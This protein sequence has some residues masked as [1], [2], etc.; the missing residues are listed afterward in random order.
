MKN[1]APTALIILDGF[2][3]SKESEF[4][5]IAQAHTPCFDKLVSLYPTTLL[6]ASGMAVG[7]PEG[8]VGNSEV[9][10]LTIGSGA[11]ILQPF[12]ILHEAIKDG[13]F[14]TNKT[15]VENFQK[16]KKENKRL[17]IM[18]ILSNAKIHGDIGHLIAFLKAAKQ[19]EIPE[20][21][22]HCFLDGIDLPIQSAKGFLTELDEA[23]EEIG[24]GKI[25]SL[26][27]RFYAMDRTRNWH[28]TEQSFYTL[29]EKQPD[30]EKDWQTALKKSY[31]ENV[32]DAFLMPVQIENT[33]Q[34]EHG[35][36]IVFFNFRR[37]RPRQLTRA[38]IRPPTELRLKPFPLSF[39]MTPFSF[40]PNYDTT[41]LYQRP[42]VTQTLSR[43][44]HE[45]GFSLFTVAETEKFPHVTYFFNGG[46]EERLPNEKVVVVPSVASRDYKVHPE[47]SAATI[48]E[49]I[50]TSLKHKPRDLYIVN[51]ANADMVGHTG[52]FEATIKGV[53]CLD[54]Q[55]AVLY[56]EFVIKRNGTMYI[57]GDHGNAEEM[58]D[59]ETG[60]VKTS[61]TTNPV[62]FI[63]IQQQLKDVLDELPLEELSDI[64]P[65]VVHN[66][67]EE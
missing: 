50:V 57:T 43:M 27:G 64:A 34:I 40:G 8:S 54:K 22:I 41:T 30:Q 66:I 2:G 12:T 14:Y 21:I 19:Q 16:L 20:V 37:D 15:L 45:K 42:K 49:A 24:L 4:N 31:A 52:D 51:Y 62:F 59:K 28:L 58:H 3:Y 33:P 47:M 32:T 46:R 13:S 63:M 5:A 10:H 17:H 29:T 7:L 56:D 9:G 18:G 65:F 53:E 38:F 25:G 55:L 48:T 35:D 36:G 39:F 1:K 61:H 23:I 67:L 60:Q 44:L 26:H 11:V 6:K